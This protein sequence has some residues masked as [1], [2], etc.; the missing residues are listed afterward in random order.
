MSILVMDKSTN[1]LLIQ[2]IITE[3]ALDVRSEE[4]IQSVQF[5]GADIQSMRKTNKT[6][7]TCPP[8]TLFCIQCGSQ[9]YIHTRRLLSLM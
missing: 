2:R 3:A 1:R 8:I 5:A 4:L 7:A 6:E 9:D